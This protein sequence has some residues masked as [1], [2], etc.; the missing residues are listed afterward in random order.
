MTM[1]IGEFVWFS[2]LCLPADRPVSYRVKGLESKITDLE[3]E[4]D[5][6]SRALEV[7]KSATLD[8]QA[9]ATR[10]VEESARELQKKV[11]L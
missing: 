5:R 8:A 1:L 2:R 9:A 11:G 6:L 4:T 3:S 10:K 7:Q